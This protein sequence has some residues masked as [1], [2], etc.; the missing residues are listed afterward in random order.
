MKQ[1]AFFIILKGLSMNQIK[2]ERQ[3]LLEGERQKLGDGRIIYL[4]MK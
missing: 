3:K 1:K 2:G 4:A